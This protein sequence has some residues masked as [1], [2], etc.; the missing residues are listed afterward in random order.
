[1][2]KPDASPGT[3]RIAR[4]RV[5]YNEQ[6]GLDCHAG[7]PFT[8]VAYSLHPDGGLASEEEFRDGLPW[9]TAR[10][11]SR[12]GG[13]LSES[14]WLRGVIH[15]AEREWDE[16][17]RLRA[18][19]VCEYGVVLRQRA[20]DEQGALTEDY[21]IEETSSDFELLQRFRRAYGGSRAP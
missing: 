11:W 10:E 3:A 16:A 1:M 4:D 2:T 5:S 21:E 13:L 17:G 9:G 15:G 19:I 18:E 6:E 7:V 14:E 12:S 20:W 8:G